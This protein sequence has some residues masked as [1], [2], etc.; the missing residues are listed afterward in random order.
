MAEDKKDNIIHLCIK[1]K[2]KSEDCKECPL[3]KSIIYCQEFIAILEKLYYSEKIKGLP[4]EAKEGI[5]NETVVSVFEW[6]PEFIAEGGRNGSQFKAMICKIFNWR[7]LDYFIKE[8]YLRGLTRVPRHEKEEKKFG[9]PDYNGEVDDVEGNEGLDKD[10]IKTPDLVDMFEPN[11]HITIEPEEEETK[12]EIIGVGDPLIAVKSEKAIK[13]VSDYG[14]FEIAEEIQKPYVQKIYEHQIINILGVF[15]A[16]FIEKSS[17][18]Q[19]SLKGKKSS[20]EIQEIKSNIRKIE[21]EKKAIKFFIDYYQM[22]KLG[23]DTEKEKAIFVKMR[24][25]TYVI[26]I[27]RHREVLLRLLKEKGLL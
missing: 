5:I 25:N 8:H 4:L 14:T 9:Q 17:Q 15:Y 20:D 27:K 3:S 21:A 16:E 19:K 24:P 10:D 1:I 6:F 26:Y 12:L 23:I 11:I 7:R 13:Y 18:L 2:G 22:E